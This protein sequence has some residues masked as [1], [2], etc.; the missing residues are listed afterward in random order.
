MKVRNHQHA[1][2]ECGVVSATM[3]S[4]S[5]EAV[6]IPIRAITVYPVAVA[7]TLRVRM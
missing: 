4:C 6:A 3:K 1:A 2:A 5:V 7:F